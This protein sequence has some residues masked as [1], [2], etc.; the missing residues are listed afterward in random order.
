LSSPEIKV[1]EGRFGAETRCHTMTKKILAVLRK[2]Q[3]VCR[4]THAEGAFSVLKCRIPLFGRLEIET[5]SSC[6]RY[7]GTCLRNTYLPREGVKS[8]FEDKKLSAGTVCRIIDEAHDL[9]YRGDVNL[10][11]YNEPL[12]D[13]RIVEFGRY[14]RNKGRP[15]SICTNG[16]LITPDRAKALDAVFNS[17]SIAL[18]M[19]EERRKKRRD[20]LKCLFTKTKLSFTD[21][22]HIPSHYGPQRTSEDLIRRYVNSRCY[23]PWRRMIINHKGEML[24]CCEDMPGHFDLGNV[25]DNSV[26]ELWFSK[27][28]QDIMWALSKSDGRRRFTHCSVCPR[29]GGRRPQSL[30]GISGM[31]Y[32]L[33]GYLN[34]NT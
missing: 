7:C 34:Q 33:Q 22:R 2:S 10:Q 12:L 8:W 28:H 31:R 3:A 13:D 5:S 16:D 1:G 17:I 6:N 9:G 25:F 15:V 24:L 30:R 32:R 4:E 23:Q 27:E 20:Y 18:Y 19:D 29:Y 14:V 26:E 11:H 21:G